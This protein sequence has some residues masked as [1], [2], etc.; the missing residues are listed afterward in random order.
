MTSLSFPKMFDFSRTKLHKDTEATLC[1]TRLLLHSCKE[2]LIGDPYFGSN[3]MKYI[4]E[5]NNVLLQDI[6]I[7]DIY[8]CITTFIP[9][10]YLTRKDIELVS[11]GTAITAVIHCI[12]KIDNTPNMYDIRLTE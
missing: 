7:D 2:T 4:Y 9:Q 12:N 11:D 1:N 10:L 8:L 3:L 6:I 5:Q